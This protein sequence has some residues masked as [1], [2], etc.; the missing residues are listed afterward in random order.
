M[1]ATTRTATPGTTTN[2]PPLAPLAVV[3]LGLMVAAVVAGVVLAGGDIFPLPYSA[4]TAVQTWL[5]EHSS[6]ARA[7]AVLQFGASVPLAIYAATAN[8]RLHR[9]GVR[10][11]GANIAFAG[12][13][14]ASAFLA[15]SALFEWTL[16]RPE[17][18]AVPG[19]LHPLYDLVYLTGGVAHVVPLG[20]LVAGIAVPGLIVRLLPRWLAVTGLVI[21]AVA[22]LSTF[23]LLWVG[24]SVLLPIARFPALIWLVVAG[25]LLPTNRHQVRQEG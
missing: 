4:G 1:A 3:T 18:I 19:L 13:L 25:A 23:S 11:P 17:T 9:V 15:L 21:A 16:S 2:G 14:L 20:L 8:A 5:T 24:A 7:V 12:G 22:E 6:S 10:A